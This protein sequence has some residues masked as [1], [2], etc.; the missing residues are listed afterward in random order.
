MEVFNP[1]LNINFLGLRKISLAVSALLIVLSIG[2]I[3]TRGLNYGLD[4]TGGLLVEAQYQQPVDVSEVRAALEAGGFDHAV[5]Q[6]IGGAREVSIRLQVTDK[7]GGAAATA[8]QDGTTAAAKADAARQPVENTKNRGD[9]VAA[10]VFKALQAKRQDVTIKPS[11][12]VGPQVG[13]ELKSDGVT[14]VLVVILGIMIYIGIRFEWRFAV[15]AIA[16]EIHD[17][18]ITVGF[19]AIT[20]HEFD[21]TVLASVLAV[22][23]YS[24]NDKVVVFDRVRELFRSARRAEPE[25]ILNKAI[26]STLSRTIITALFTAVTMVALYFFGGPVVHGFALTMLIGIV[27]GTLSSIFF[28][29]P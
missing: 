28:A 21:I 5:V 13:E 1:N 25:E 29:S 6:S 27:V 2:A 22:V 23:G 8:T 4:F 18:L 24:I 19:Y 12:F 14:A 10:A 15:A 16:S 9:E 7:D 26:N 3:L 17:T 20:Q 11:A